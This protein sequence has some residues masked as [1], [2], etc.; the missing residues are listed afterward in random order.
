MPVPEWRGG[1]GGES[2]RDFGNVTYRGLEGRVDFGNVYHGMVEG[3]R[4]GFG[5]I[6][7]MRRRDWWREKGVMRYVCIEL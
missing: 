5:G 3:Q 6:C 2:W 7:H 4:A 1:K